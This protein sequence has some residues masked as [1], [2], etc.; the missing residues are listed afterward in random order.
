MFRGEPDVFY[1]YLHALIQLIICLQNL[2]ALFGKGP[3]CSKFH[4]P[5]KENFASGTLH[6]LIASL[7]FISIIN[8]FVLL[9]LFT[10]LF[11]F[12]TQIVDALGHPLV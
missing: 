8:D 12:L 1:M 10:I 7:G 3:A 6:S 2:L 11:K 9:V 5:P 4:V